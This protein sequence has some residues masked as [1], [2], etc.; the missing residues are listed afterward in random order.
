MKKLWISVE[1]NFLSGQTDVEIEPPRRQLTPHAF[2]FSIHD[3]IGL[4]Y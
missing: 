1:V 4:G 3:E 2:L